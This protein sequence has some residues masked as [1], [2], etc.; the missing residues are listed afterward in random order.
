MPQ[1]AFSVSRENITVGS[2]SS[3]GCIAVE[4]VVR[5]KWQTRT[6]PHVEWTDVANTETT[7]KLCAYAPSRPGEY[8]LAAEIRADGRIGRYSSNLI[9]KE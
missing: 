1:R 2:R 5:S 4:E 7:G 8:R 3:E 6:A 9:E